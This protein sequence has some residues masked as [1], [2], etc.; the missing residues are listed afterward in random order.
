MMTELASTGPRVRTARLLLVDDEPDVRKLC[1]DLFEEAGYAV[2]SAPDA[3]SGAR[4]ALEAP[5]DVAVIDYRLPDCRGTA[6]VRWLRK[7]YPKM[8]LIVFS[9]YADWDMFFKAGGIGARDVV[10]KTAS[11]KE[12][13]RIVEHSLSH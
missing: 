4:A 3:K 2:T 10:A 12:L 9:A 7:R 13:L 11:P 1:T 6:L 8:A 5:Y